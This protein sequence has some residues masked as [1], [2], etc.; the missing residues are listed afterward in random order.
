MHLVVGLGNPGRQYADT[1]HNA[2]FLVVDRLAERWGASLGKRQFK[3]DVG[4]AR[5][6][7]VPAVLCKP[8][9]FMNLSG[10]AVVSL[11]GYYKSENRDV[12]VIHD[13]VELP[14]GDVRVKSG[15]GHGGHNGLR[16]IS[17]RIGADYGRVRFGVG[18]PPEGWD[19]ADFVLAKWSGDESRQ[20]DEV[21]DRAAD[22]VERALQESNL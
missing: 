3:A 2:G 8:Q 13:D 18:R 19:T 16:D 15:G 9:T 4:Q 14:F 11:R 5:I 21:V 6:G 12:L 17:K 20:L 7:S 10:E 1:R 22:A